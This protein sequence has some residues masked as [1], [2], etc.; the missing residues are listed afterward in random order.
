MS[1][2]YEV[3][4]CHR[5]PETKR[6]LVSVLNGML[7]L[8][9]ITSFVDYE[10]TE[11]TQINPAIEDAIKNSYVHIVILSPDFE[12]SKW[13][14]DEVLQIMSMQSSAGTSRRPRKV[15]PI[16]CDVDRSM[17]RERAVR[18]SYNVRESSPEEW[19]RWGE[20]VESLCNFKGFEYH[21]KATLQWEKL[22]EIVVEVE[23][24]LKGVDS[25]SSILP[26]QGQQRRSPTQDYDVFVCY[27]GSDTKHNMVSVLRGMLHLEGISCFNNYD[28]SHETERKPLIEEAMK[29]SKVYVIFLSPDFAT[30][31]VCLEEVYQI[32]NTLNSPGTPY[33][34]R[35]VIPIFYDV[36][37]F[38]VRYQTKRYVLSRVSESTDEQRKGWSQSLKNLSLRKGFEFESETMFQWEELKKFLKRVKT[39]L[40]EPRRKNLYAKQL[41]EVEK[42]LESRIC[43]DVFLIGIHG[44]NKSQ[45][46]ELLVEKICTEFDGL[47]MLHNVIEKLRE[48]NGLSRVMGEL[49]SDLI[50]ISDEE[51][52]KNH[53]LVHGSRYRQILRTK[54]CLVILPDVENEIHQMRQLVE[55]F[56]DILSNSSLVVLSC[57]FKH[58]LRE[59]MKVDKLIEL[60]SLQDSKGT[61]IICHGSRSHV[62]EAYVDHLHET[63]CFYGL[64]VHLLSVEKLLSDTDGV[65]NAKV[66]L[67]ISSN[68][69]SIE[70]F[71]KMLSDPVFYSTE[72]IYILYGPQGMNKSTS[73]PCFKIEVN[74]ENSEFN[75][76]EFKTM[77]NKVV[78]MLSKGDQ[79]T[80]QEVIEFP[81]GLKQRVDVMKS[82]ILTDM[83][84]SDTSL[85]CFGI[86]GMGGAGK[87]TIARSIYNGMHMHFDKSHL[88]SNTRA[89]FVN[90][91]VVD[92][93]KDIV[94][95][96]LG[97]L[98]KETEKDWEH[99]W[100][101]A[102]KGINAL[103]VLDDVDSEQHLEALYHPLC[104]SLGPKSV[105]IMTSRDRRVLESTQPKDIFLIEGF[106]NRKHSERLFYWHAFLKAEPPAHLLQVSS[107][108]IDACQG[109][110]LSLKVM[111][112]H[113]YGR[114]DESYWDESLLWLQQNETDIF[115]K[116]RIS[117]NGLEPKQMEAFLD[118]C[119][120]LIGEEEGT[121]CS[122]LQ[123]CYG[124]GRTYLEV[125]RNRCLIGISDNWSRH[126]MGPSRII[127]VHDQIR[128][129]GRRIVR[130]EKR[131]RAWDEETAENIFKDEKARSTLR[132]LSI[133]SDFSFP[134]EAT[135]CRSLPHLK[136]LVVKQVDDRDKGI[137]GMFSRKNFLEKVRCEELRWLKWRETPFRNV[138]LGMCSKSLR[139]LDLAGSPIKRVAIGSLPNLQRL[140]LSSCSKL[141]SFDSSIGMLKDLRYLNLQWCDHVK[142]LTEE[143][144][145]LQSLEL[146]TLANCTSLRTLSSL[147]T[148]LRTLNLDECENLESLKASSSLP[149]LRALRLTS[150][151][152]LKELDCKGFQ[153]L[154]YLRLF[155]CYQLES[156]ETPALP[157]LRDLE[158]QMCKQLKEVD[159]GGCHSLER[160][161][162]ECCYQLESLEIPSL[163]NLRHL[164]LQGCEQLKEVDYGGCQSL[165]RLQ[166]TCC[167][168]LKSLKMPSLPNLRHLL[169]QWCNQLKEVDYGGCHSLEHLDLMHCDELKSLE[170]PSLPNLRRLELQGCK[171]LKEVD[172]GGCQSL[173]HLELIQRDELKS[174]EMLSLLN[175]GH[176]VLGECNGLKSLEMPSLP[177]LR[178]LELYG[179]RGFESLEMP[180]LP[181]LRHL[182]LSECYGLE[183]LEMPSL[184]NLRKLDLC[185]CEQLKEVVCGDCQSLEYFAVVYCYQLE[186]LKMP[187][188]PKLELFSVRWSHNLKE[189]DC[190]GLPS[191]DVLNVDECRSLQ[192]ISFLPSSLGILDL[193][194]CF[195]LRVLDGLNTL[196]NL[197]GKRINHIGKKCLPMNIWRT[198]GLSNGWE[199]S[200]K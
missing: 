102:I 198:P 88:C 63:F 115:K 161:R 159:C 84:E 82:R 4:I 173:E 124:L 162:L 133:S 38:E 8:K 55:R 67:C 122:V 196:T 41:D 187:S 190:G 68:T 166:L 163:P 62:H 117:L 180:S 127:E 59:V 145:G 32:M 143:I 152:K 138:P 22:S 181:N 199:K 165:E 35:S 91:G 58:M 29:K 169:L 52:P 164:E 184:P 134:K 80:N 128:D 179:C 48:E 97:K 103:I 49:F 106:E 57:D 104:S 6:N 37:P 47:S 185:A 108:I 121:A 126:D 42:V 50:R 75:K 10:M 130:D 15:I 93:Q 200:R 110:P 129:M 140:D 144:E 141:K 170:M 96:M 83:Q 85:L 51:P 105:L 197:R 194:Y 160:L 76:T 193:N 167:Y 36:K 74:S 72:I 53:E 153:S 195:E 171:Q 39:S 23:D 70:D 89:D 24:F 135:K 149:N 94:R 87:T 189:L 191:L 66:I 33:T 186:S 100:K 142:L 79:K 11:G 119:C 71:E 158:L 92:M 16:F 81:V 147:A 146:L 73:K 155:H 64:D 112:A 168:E 5:G 109:L 95:G 40:K 99:K 132:G 54:K 183:S 177:N 131:D 13:C 118:I 78:E 136:I 27:M 65:R 111:G 2:H 151:R 12:N 101:E 3:F 174:L 157:N 19:K 113:L 21:S 69:S 1:A 25:R 28:M 154:E 17:V 98:N 178:H 61:L 188:L 150:C 116:L 60:P 20:A 45:F 139:V 156:L 107:R 14:L 172:Y 9:G 192:R 148:T 26:E 123:G 18:L 182:E 90:K 31:N 86:W 46:V 176:L 30:S 77:V 56:K 120:F 43:K 34:A 175:L 44:P 137:W 7:G 125:L 114:D